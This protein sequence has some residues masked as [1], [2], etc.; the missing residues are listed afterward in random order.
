[1]MPALAYA[2]NKIREYLILTKSKMIQTMTAAIPD[3]RMVEYLKNT[4]KN[5]EWKWLRKRCKS[6]F[7]YINTGTNPARRM[8]RYVTR[9]NL[10][11]LAK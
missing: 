4:S 6:A 7:V 2:E 3:P 8:T 11:F 10:F 1:M 5:G 9:N